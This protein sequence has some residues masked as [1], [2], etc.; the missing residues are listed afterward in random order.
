MA[1]GQ[2]PV[3]VARLHGGS[4]ASDRVAGGTNGRMSEKLQ[5][6]AA[7]TR[8]A[9]LARARN[10]RARAAEARRRGDER[11]ALFH[12][13]AAASHLASAMAAEE[14]FEADVQVEGPRLE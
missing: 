6:S 4:V 1:G 9:T 7:H 14:V 10:A 8:E 5:R 3:R 11:A 2:E 12:D 13:A